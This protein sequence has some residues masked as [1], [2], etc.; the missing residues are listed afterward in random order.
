MSFQLLNLQM[1]E[2]RSCIIQRKQLVKMSAALPLNQ[3][4]DN[5]LDK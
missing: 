4:G 5:I 2:Q 1:V 3:M